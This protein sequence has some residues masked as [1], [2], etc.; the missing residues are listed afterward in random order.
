MQ[1]DTY[2]NMW[3][4]IAAVNGSSEAQENRDKVAKR[5]AS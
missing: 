2:A 4:N 3:W 5:M 1:D